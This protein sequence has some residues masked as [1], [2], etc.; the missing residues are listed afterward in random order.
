M[1]AR[2]FVALALVGSGLLGC[3]QEPRERP[4]VACADACKKRM[5]SCT[6]HQCE[7]GCAFVIDRLVEHQQDTV[8]ACIVKSTNCDDPAWADCA[9]RVGV[10]ADGGPGAPTH[11][12]DEGE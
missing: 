2:S 1:I 11:I 7:R 5:V 12:E 8:L 10:H 3:P 6:E 9:V 4:D